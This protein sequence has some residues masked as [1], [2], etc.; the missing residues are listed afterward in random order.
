MWPSVY[1][2]GSICFAVGA[3]SGSWP[4]AILLFII[5]FCAG[6]IIWHLSRP[7]SLRRLTWLAVFVFIAFTAVHK[8]SVIYGV[9]L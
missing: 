7:I 6:G 4:L 9:S 5:C 2:L 3:V 8:F 1:I